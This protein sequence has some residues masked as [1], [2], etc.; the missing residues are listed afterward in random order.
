MLEHRIATRDPYRT[1]YKNLIFSVTGQ[2]IRNKLEPTGACILDLVQGSIDSADTD[3]FIHMVKEELRTRN[4]IGLIRYG[5]SKEQFAAW[6]QHPVSG[7]SAQDAVP[8]V[9]P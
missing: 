5:V 4:E 9:S 1:K 3:R 6:L 2:I 7:R 8:T